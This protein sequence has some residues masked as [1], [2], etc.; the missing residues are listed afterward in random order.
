MY[1]KHPSQAVNYETPVLSSRPTAG[2]GEICDLYGLC[3]KKDPSAGLSA[4]RQARD[5]NFVIQS[6]KGLGRVRSLTRRIISKRLWRVGESAWILTFLLNNRMILYPRR[7]SKCITAQARKNYSS[8]TFT[9]PLFSLP[10]IWGGLGR[11]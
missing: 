10:W 4:G 6:P 2:S 1:L 11:G 9:F 3:L 8:R 5:D 7:L